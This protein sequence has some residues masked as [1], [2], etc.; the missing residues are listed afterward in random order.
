MALYYTLRDRKTNALVVAKPVQFEAVEPFSRSEKADFKYTASEELDPAVVRKLMGQQSVED[1]WGGMLDAA[2]VNMKAQLLKDGY[3]EEQI[4]TICA[5]P[6]P[7]A[8]V[9]AI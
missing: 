1:V 7:A 2:A 3:T 5:K 9:E 6:L 8:T 4:K